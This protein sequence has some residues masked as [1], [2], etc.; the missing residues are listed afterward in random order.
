MNRVGADPTLRGRC[1]LW[2]PKSVGEMLASGT[3]YLRSLRRPG[4]QKNN[5]SKGD[6]TPE[7]GKGGVSILG[8]SIRTWK[9][10][11]GWGVFYFVKDKG[12]TESVGSDVHITKGKHG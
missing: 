7:K 5:I 3:S 2:P 8:G 9:K 11:R 4:P 10:R 6:G 12:G 1:F